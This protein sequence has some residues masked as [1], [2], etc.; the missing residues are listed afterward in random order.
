MGDVK[1]NHFFKRIDFGVPE[2]KRALQFFATTSTSLR[3]GQMSSP[4][5][6][7]ETKGVLMSAL[8]IGELVAASETLQ[9]LA[10]ETD[11]FHPDHQLADRAM[12]MRLLLQLASL[13]L[14]DYAAGLARGESPQEALL[15]TIGG[16]SKLPPGG[17]EAIQESKRRSL[18]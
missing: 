12:E 2:R 9:K 16:E 11:A 5:V 4:R 14:S 8:H 6:L 18:S 7:P 15:T 13:Y 17:I 3:P 1:L 10:E